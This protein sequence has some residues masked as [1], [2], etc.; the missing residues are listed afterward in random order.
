MYTML[1]ALMTVVVATAIV[2]ADHEAGHPAPG[3]K[4][5]S[6]I[7]ATG[8]ELCENM[9]G[10]AFTYETNEN[11]GYDMWW[12]SGGNPNGA[13]SKLL[14][15]DAAPATCGLAGDYYHKET[16]GPETDTHA[17]RPYKD[18]ACCKDETIK[19][20]QTIKAS[21]GEE[22]HWDRCGPMSQACEAYFVYEACFYECEP[23]AGL[24]RKWTVAQVADK[25]NNPDANTWQMEGMPIKA[26]FCDGWLDACRDDMFCSADDGDFFSCAAIYEA[27]DDAPP[28]GGGAI[29]GIVIAV[30]VAVLALAFVAVLIVR[31]RKGRPVF[32]P[33]SRDDGRTAT[34]KV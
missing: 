4:K 17:C 10:G 16:P 15:K 34:P 21:Y 24:F 9:W 28:L 22:Y 31:E 18:N 26:S 19:D 27:H 33:L 20:A 8:K 30:I 14:G 7:Y 13:I 11:R 12:T 3:C 5:F 2:S 25:E 1:R 29:A 6:E 23:A 32:V